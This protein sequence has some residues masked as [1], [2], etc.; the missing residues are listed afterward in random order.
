MREVEAWCGV[1]GDG[2]QRGCER[3]GGQREDIPRHEDG[4]LGAECG[5]EDLEGLD[6]DGSA[7]GCVAGAWVDGQEVD[8]A[9]LVGS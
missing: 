9:I 2:E 8:V 3:Q 5:C 4:D 1:V 6:V 7:G